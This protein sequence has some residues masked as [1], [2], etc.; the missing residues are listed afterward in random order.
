MKALVLIFVG[1]GLGSV[2][3]FLLG[4]WVTGIHNLNFPLGTLAVNAVACFVLGL[5]V[6][7]VDHKQ[8]LS[9]DMRIF[10]AVGFCG[11]FSTFSTFSYETLLLFQQP[12]LMSGIVYVLASVALCLAATALGV[13]I[14]R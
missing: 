2:A 4:R 8:M 5:I 11:G 12:A 1:G 13:A 7:F 3:R 9:A 14:A 6:G 10:W